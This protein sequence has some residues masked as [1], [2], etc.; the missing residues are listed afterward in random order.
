MTNIKLKHVDSFRDRHGRR[1]Y[2][3]RRDRGPRVPLPGIP[4]SAEF[5]A[6]YQAALVDQVVRRSPPKLHGK[7]G[8]FNRLV[9]DYF[10]SADF[11]S[12]APSTQKTYRAVVERLIIDENIGHRLVGEMTRDHVRRIVAKRASTPGAANDV[13]KK[14]KVLIHFAIDY[15]WRHDDPTLRAKMFPKGEIHTWTEDEIGAFERH[16]PIGSTPRL[17]F[18]LL[19]YTGQRRSDV[20]SMSWADVD[21]ETIC[22]VPKKTQRSTGVKLWIPIHPALAETLEHADRQTETILVTNYS[23]AFAATGFGNYFADKIDDAGLPHRCVTHGLRKAAARRLAEAG[24]TANEI[25]SITGHATLQ[26]VSRY[27]KAAEQRLLAKTAMKRLEDKPPLPPVERVIA[28]QQP[29]SKSQTSTKGLGF[30]PKTSSNS[31]VAS[32][33]WRS[34]GESNPSFQNENL[35]S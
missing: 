8:T 28:R 27:T 25:A 30:V 12:L 10:S 5:M 1:R 15:G 17:A 31:T 9:K 3:F 7:P 6:T 26:E 19:L 20:V 14:L 18:A 13:L 33:D 24:C 2:Y 21:D 32:E 11:K 29:P 16:W 35:T 23:R 4:G 22:V 34:L